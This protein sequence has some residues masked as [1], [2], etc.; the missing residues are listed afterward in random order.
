MEIELDLSKTPEQ[1]AEKYFEKAKKA[2]SKIDGIESTI[3]EQKRKLSRLEEEEKKRIRREEERKE[4]E[5]KKKRKAEWYEKFRWFYSSEG[6]LV[7]GGRDATSNEIVVKKNTDSDD[8]VFHTDMA[9]SP[10]FVVKRHSLKSEEGGEI[11]IGDNTLHEAADAVCTYSKAWKLGMATTEVFWVRPEQVTKTAQPGEFV[12]RGAF[13]IRGKTNYVRAKV[14]LAIG[15]LEDGRVMAGP[16]VAVR[17]HCSNYVELLQGNEKTSSV[18][19]QVRKLVGGEIDEIV[20]L[21]PAGGAK[22]RRHGRQAR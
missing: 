22:V 3:A 11:S 13:M 17:T 1:N 10:F 8:I 5:E 12:P 19:R 20:R 6:F 21:I 9:G 14:N 16:L 2:R 18:A 15:M 4:R 7:I